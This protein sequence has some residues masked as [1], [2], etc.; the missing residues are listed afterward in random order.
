MDLF[1][2]YAHEDA[3]FVERLRSQLSARDHQVWLDTQDIE[4]SDRWRGSAQE[5]IE[6]SDAFLFVLSRTSL[7]SRACL[8]ELDYAVSLNKRLIAICVEEAA[9]DANKPQALDELSWI[10]MRPQDDFDRGVETL[11]RALETDLELVRTHTRILVRARAWELGGRRASPLLRGE[12]L[13]RAEDWLVRASAGRAPAP[14]ELQRAFIV[15]SRRAATRR[16]ATIAGVA[17][18][19]AVIAVVLSVFALIQRSDAINNQHIAESRLLA[20]D[21]EAAV[22]SDPSLSTLLALDALRIH[23]TSQAEEALRDA[24]SNLRVLAVF[25]GH[26]GAVQM[27]AYSRDGSRIVTAAADGTARIWDA[28]TTKQLLV[29]HVERKG[30]LQDAQFSPDGSKV[31]TCGIDHLTRVWNAHTGRLIATLKGDTD[32]VDTAVFNPQGTRVLTASADGW[33][34]VWDPTTAKQI[35]ALPGTK[36]PFLSA[37]YSPDGNAI[38]TVNYDGLVRLWDARSGRRLDQFHVSSA[39]NFN[40]PTG[41]TGMSFSPDGSRVAIAANPVQL[42]NIDRPRRLLTLTDPDSGPAGSTTAQFSPDGSRLVTTAPEIW[43]ATSGTPLLVLGNAVDTSLNSVIQSAAFSPD[44]SR[45][46]TGGPGNS[47]ELWIARSLGQLTEDK[48]AVAFSTTVNNA[49]FSPD[50]S[51]IVVGRSD[52][53]QIWNIRTGTQIRLIKLPPS[54]SQIFAAFSPDGTKIATTAAISGLGSANYPTEIWDAR[55]GRLLARM[56]SGPAGEGARVAFSPDGSK[57]VTVGGIDAVTV[58]VWDVHSGRRLVS[59]RPP[60]VAATV[61]DATFS[62]DGSRLVTANDDGSVRV[63]NSRD[64]RQLADCAGSGTT[65]AAVF[66][67]DGSRLASAGGDGTATIWDARTCRA[68][69]V[70]RGHTGAVHDVAFSPDGS[71]VATGGED[72]TVRIWDAATG[73]QLL[74]LSGHGGPVETVQFSRDGSELLTAAQDDSARIWTTMLAGPIPSLERLARSL[75]TRPFTAAER[76]EYLAGISG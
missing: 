12:E 48:V 58:T 22:T 35:W 18:V 10:M 2:S 65:L 4:P 5:G 9:A 51:S 3:G 1:I 30:S 47:A 28:R 23:D 16:Q 32:W 52:D 49:S 44:G 56:G 59:I 62:R 15:A 38:A 7:G 67:P 36:T 53:A 69:V 14:T 72:K 37:A 71:K 76:A 50:G 57:L 74:V 17:T 60:G 46:L 68:L 43:N 42:W 6:R 73:Q 70:L 13:K 8:E 64:G 27:A 31:V 55:T 63:W 40:T 19:V 21:A 45:I 61:W 24:L 41:A 33:T 26:T 54:E 34:R 75:V 20:T 25:R 39:A 66:S 11:M 29:L